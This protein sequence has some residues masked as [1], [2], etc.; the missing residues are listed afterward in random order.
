MD[1]QS[2]YLS[3]EQRAGARS[4]FYRY[5]SVEQAL[6]ADREDSS[7]YQL[8]NGDDWKFSWAVKP[9]ERIAEKDADFNQTDYDDSGWDDISV[10]RRLADVCK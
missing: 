9:S 10:P 7:S 8:L 5:D 6:A 4:T 1:E 3:G 2:G